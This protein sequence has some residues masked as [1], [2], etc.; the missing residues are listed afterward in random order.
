MKKPAVVNRLLIATIMFFLAWA[1]MGTI[2]RTDVLFWIIGAVILFV[3]VASVLY[4]ARLPVDQAEELV[5]R[6]NANPLL[7]GI[8]V[9][10]ILA[11]AFSAC[12]YVLFEVIPERIQ[13]TIGVEW[14]WAVVLTAV[15]G[16]PL[17]G[18][19]WRLFGP[20]GIP[21]DPEVI[22]RAFRGV[23]FLILVF[24]AWWYHNQPNRMFDVETGQATFWVDKKEGKI[25]FF[26][27]AEDTTKKYFSPATG[28]ELQRGNTA[29]AEK[30]RKESWVKEASVLLPSFTTKAE[31]ASSRTRRITVVLRGE[32]IP[33]EPVYAPTGSEVYFVGGPTIE[34]ED[35]NGKRFPLHGEHGVTWSP[36][37]FFGPKGETVFVDVVKK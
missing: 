30:Y 36:Y 15:L 27:G 22:R 21:G 3:L 31:S 29:D 28:E 2:V 11:L 9:F 25:Y 34:G 13:G 18:I 5:K 17:I 7:K 1:L 19:A 26:S 32:K 6:V 12:L 33:T 23:S 37:R 16:L 20:T 4:I 10:T 24:F 14:R 8:V 35:G